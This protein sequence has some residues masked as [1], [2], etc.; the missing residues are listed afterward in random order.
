[1]IANKLPDPEAPNAEQTRK[2][3]TMSEL[4]ASMLLVDVDADAD[5]TPLPEHCLGRLSAVRSTPRP[6]SHGSYPAYAPEQSA[7]AWRGADAIV[8]ALLIA[9][10][11]VSAA[12]YLLTR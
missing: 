2:V 11:A 7:R 8:I 5:A 12:A 1:M 10:A 9:L 4:V 6:P 3:D